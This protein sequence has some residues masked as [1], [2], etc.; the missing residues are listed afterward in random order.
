M[1]LKRFRWA[2]TR[3]KVDVHIDFPIRGLNMSNYVM[4][5]L[6]E[7]R[8]SSTMND[9]N[10]AAVIVHHG[11]G[12]GCGH[13]TSYAIHEGTYTTAPEPAAAITRRTLYMKVRTPQH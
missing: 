2:Q 9:Y 1:H 11:T 8:H 10:L 5:D 13:Y 12:A 7:T 3:V 6:H 4:D